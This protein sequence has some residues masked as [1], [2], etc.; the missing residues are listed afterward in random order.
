MGDILEDQ[1]VLVP[2]YNA[3][4]REVPE[5]LERPE[6]V[7]AGLLSGLDEKI[8]E[9]EKLGAQPGATNTAERAAKLRA[10]YVDLKGTAKNATEKQATQ[11]LEK[12]TAE[13][14]ELCEQVTAELTVPIRDAGVVK[15]L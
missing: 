11:K 7:L 10:R 6:D 15:A 12:T 2:I 9:L 1:K 4:D 14:T 13:V 8:G 5:N 3:F